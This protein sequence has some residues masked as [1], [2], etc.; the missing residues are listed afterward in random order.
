VDSAWLC[1]VLNKNLCTKGADFAYKEMKRLTGESFVDF[2]MVDDG[3]DNDC[4]SFVK[5]STETDVFMDGFRK[6][7][8]I[9]TVLD[10]YD[11]PTLLSDEEVISFLTDGEKEE[12]G[13]KYGDMVLVEGNGHYSGLH[14]IVVNGG[15]V[16]SEV[17]FRFHT[18]TRR[19]KLKN[20]DLQI[21]GNV[22]K[23]LKIPVTNVTLMEGRSKF[24][25]IKKRK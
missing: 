9:V 17:L 16:E 21:T 3:F 10:S 12:F 15:E 20:E 8:N 2:K 1:V 24:P 4:Y 11:K 23:R 5:C 13:T 25:V 22:F 7:T 18:I 14:G 6:S 19:K